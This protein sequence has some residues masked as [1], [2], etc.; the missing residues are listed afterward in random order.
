MQLFLHLTL[1]VLML[2]TFLTTEF[3]KPLGA[4]LIVIWIVAGWVRLR[5]I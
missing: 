2:V 1:G 4:A 5:R 3:D